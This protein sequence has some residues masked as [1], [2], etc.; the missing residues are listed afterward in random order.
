MTKTLKCNQ[1]GVIDRTT[2]MWYVFFIMHVWYDTMYVKWHEHDEHEENLIV[3]GIGLKRTNCD[4]L[5]LK[6][7]C[8]SVHSWHP[9]KQLTLVGSYS[10]MVFLV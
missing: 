9:N 6:C 7:T 3:S 8:S 5:C 4:V 2:H 1:N 10:S